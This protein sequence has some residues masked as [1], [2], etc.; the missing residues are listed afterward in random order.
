M[1]TNLFNAKVKLIRKL[2]EKGYTTEKDILKIGISEFLDLNLTV[3]EQQ[4]YRSLI[5][6]IAKGGLLAFLAD[7]PDDSSENTTN[8]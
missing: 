2:I 7:L 4:L 1:D 5:E 6:S 3:V 8:N